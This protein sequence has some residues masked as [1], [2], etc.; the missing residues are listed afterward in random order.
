[1][2]KDSQET[3]K[4]AGVNI[5]EVKNLKPWQDKVKPVIDKYLSE[6]KDVL[7]AIDKARK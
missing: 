1:M 4:K 7:D 6:Y 2:E 5:V 3:I